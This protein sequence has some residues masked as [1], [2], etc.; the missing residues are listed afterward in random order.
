MDKEENDV[1]Q[2]ISELK[3]DM[4][5]MSQYEIYKRYAYITLKD[6][7]TCCGISTVNPISR[8]DSGIIRDDKL[9]LFNQEDLQILLNTLSPK[10]I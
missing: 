7:I 6:I 5:D 2:I 8:N 10:D 9:N 1:Y 4:E 3:K